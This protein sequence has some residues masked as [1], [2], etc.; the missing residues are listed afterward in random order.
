MP[1]TRA[2]G[3]WTPLQLDVFV[4]TFLY[5]AS[6]TVNHPLMPLAAKRLAGEELPIILGVLGASFPV[7]K[8]I[9]APLLGWLAGNSVWL[10]VRAPHDNRRS[11]VSIHFAARRG[12]PPVTTFLDV[13]YTMHF[14]FS[15]YR[16][17]AGLLT[18]DFILVADLAP[19]TRIIFNTFL[20]LYIA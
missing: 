8:A 20:I 10:S 11:A 13:I 17:Y 7:C 18:A 19:V 1:Q 4:F 3:P 6:C 2:R 12:E 5:A 9:G 15:I 14:Q 16:G